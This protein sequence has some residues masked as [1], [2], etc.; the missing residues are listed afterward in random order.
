MGNL[1]VGMYMY[2]LRGGR[3][4]VQI[5]PLQDFGAEM[6]E[7][8]GAFTL[9]WAY[10][11]NITV[12]VQSWWHHCQYAIANCT[13][14]LTVLPTNIKNAQCCNNTLQ[15][16]FSRDLISSLISKLNIMYACHASTF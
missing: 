1:N 13:S 12:H 7:G 15:I 6:K 8:G 5:T 10:T 14:T 2:K 16:F 11:P 4:L 3:I 9:G